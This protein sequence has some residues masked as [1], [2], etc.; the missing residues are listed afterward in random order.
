MNCLKKLKKLI[1]DKRLCEKNR[2]ARE[3]PDLA[4]LSSRA[5]PVTKY[6]DGEGRLKKPFCALNPLANRDSLGDK[7]YF[8]S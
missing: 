2:P 6:V 7:T 4:I 1:K 8:F 5:L 3:S